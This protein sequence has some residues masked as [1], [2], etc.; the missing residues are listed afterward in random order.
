MLFKTTM[1][2]LLC[3]CLIY[4]F[5]GRRATEV[6]NSKST[7]VFLSLQFY[8]SLPH[9]FCCCP[10]RCT[11]VK[12]CSVFLDNWPLYHILCHSLSLVIYLVLEYILSIIIVNPAFFCFMEACYNFLYPI[13]LNLSESLK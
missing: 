1:S 11:Y 12:E 7:F 9:V 13:T 2:L 3:A 8:E 4:Q 6:E 5:F 10:V